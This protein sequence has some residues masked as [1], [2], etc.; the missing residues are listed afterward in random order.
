[1]L[2]I[3]G[4]LFVLTLPAAAATGCGAP[5]EQP[6]RT[7]KPTTA[8]ARVLDIRRLEHGEPP[9]IAWSS[10]TLLNGDESRDVLPAAIDQFAETTQ[11]LVIRDVEG[12]VFAYSPDGPVGTEPIGQA[13]GG[14]AINAERNLVAWIAP[15]GSPMVL[16][17]GQARPAQLEQPAGGIS[18]GDAIAVLGHDCFNGP[19]TVQGA[20]CSVYYRA[21]GEPT[22]SF[23]TS[24]HGFAAPADEAG[25]IRGAQDADEDAVVGWTRLT[26]DQRACSALSSRPA[27]AGTPGSAWR[28]CTHLPLQFSPDGT[29]V[30]ATQPE[31]FEGA[32][33]GEITVLDRA[34][35]KAL[36]TLRNSATS[37]A[38]VVSMTWEDDEHVLAVVNQGLTWAIVR[39]G[40]D[41]TLE[42]AGDPVVPSEELER[43]PFHL[44]VQP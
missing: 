4:L 29:H 27:A 5:A 12:R 6:Q 42:Y 38:F 41:G 23:V 2:R 24:N 3:V 21:D 7:D 15:D 17:E 35:G 32:G 44:A 37:Q 26:A 30:L 28:T 13:T 20:G 16:Q 11:L 43:I 40:L 34:T 25:R 8:P 19:E 36:M 22:R 1:M 18:G 31:G 33:A 9:A 10:G 39:V 14:L